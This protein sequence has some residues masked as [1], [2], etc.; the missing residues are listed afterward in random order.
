MEYITSYKV[1]DGDEI[2]AIEFATDYRIIIYLK[3][4]RT[5]VADAVISPDCVGKPARD[6]C[7]VLDVKIY[8]PGEM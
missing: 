7:A 1:I 3:D 2:A 6:E 4:G 8:E 5:I